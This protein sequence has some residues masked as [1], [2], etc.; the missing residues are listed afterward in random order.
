MV[1]SPAALVIAHPG[2]ELRLYHWLE[3][4]KPLVFVITDGSGAGSSRIDS[5]REVLD[6]TRCTAGSIMASFTDREIYQSFVSGN[7]DRVAAMTVA[8][9]HSLIEHEIVSVVADAFEFYNPTH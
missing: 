8:I 9:A 7:V 1:P 6:A 3:L 5:T 2:H 4:A